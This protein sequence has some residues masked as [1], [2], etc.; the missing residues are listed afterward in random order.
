[1]LFDSANAI[2]FILVS[3]TFIYPFWITILTSFAGNRESM[4][5][6]FHLWISEWQTQAYKFAFSRFGNIWVP[7]K[8]SIFRTVVGTTIIVIVTLLG[9][10]PLSKKRLP[11]RNIITIIFLITMF[12]GGGLIPT[13]LL[14]R[15]IGLINNRLVYILPIATNAYY[16]II[17]RNFLMTIDDAYEEA[18]LADGAN[19]FQILV[20]IMI[21]L[22]KPILATIAL[23]AAVAHWNAWFD[24]LIYVTDESK[25]VL[26][27]FLRRLMTEVIAMTENMERFADTEMLD[28]PSYSVQAAVTILTI[29][30]IILVYPFIQKYFIKG[31]FI[32]SLKG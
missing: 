29:G 26:Q 12:F 7:Y 28:M 24:G 22:S 20:Q 2:F 1:M 16:I 15:K 4:S 30:P 21:P 27:L 11:G 9:A 17:T 32:G 13:Y 14:I 8:N 6:G 19:Y 31:I 23:W 5:L 10:Y 25:H 18:A 3:I